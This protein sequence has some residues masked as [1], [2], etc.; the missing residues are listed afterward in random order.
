MG[1]P[2][3]PY[4]DL[5]QSGTADLGQEGR[6]WI[7]TQQARQ[8]HHLRMVF[9]HCPMTVQRTWSTISVIANQAANFLGVPCKILD[10]VTLSMHVVR[11]NAR[12]NVSSP[13]KVV[14]LVDM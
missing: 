13:R 14:H 4:L 2:C 9:D 10:R 12:H 1:A 3:G 8:R 11:W 7:E 5:A 6:N